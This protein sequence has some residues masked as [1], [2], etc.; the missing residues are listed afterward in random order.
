MAP[1]VEKYNA[2]KDEWHRAEVNKTAFPPTH[3]PQNPS[4]RRRDSLPTYDQSRWIPCLP[5]LLVKM[6]SLPTYINSRWIPCGYRGAGRFFGVKPRL[7]GPRPYPE[8]TPNT[9][10]TQGG[11]AGGF[12]AASSGWGNGMEEV[13]TSG[14]EDNSAEDRVTASDD[15][16]NTAEEHATTSDDLANPAEKSK[17]DTK[18]EALMLILDISKDKARMVL[19]LTSASD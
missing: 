17:E 4:K 2:W 1:E 14:H 19:A 7:V 13:I 5:T 3:P 9:W 8:S 15:W 11:A 12:V 6:D 10:L 18:L 16:A